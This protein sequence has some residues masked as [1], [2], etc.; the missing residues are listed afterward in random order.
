KKFLICGRSAV[1]SLAPTPVSSSSL[2]LAFSSL[3]FCFCD[4]VWRSFSPFLVHFRFWPTVVAEFV[5]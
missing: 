3:F 2:F 1:A 4:L 5:R